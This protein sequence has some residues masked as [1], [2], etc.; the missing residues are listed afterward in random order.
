[1]KKVQPRQR[2]QQKRA[3]P[4]RYVPHEHKT[5]IRGHSCSFR[6]PEGLHYFKFKRF[7]NGQRLGVTWREAAAKVAAKHAQEEQQALQPIKLKLGLNNA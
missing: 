3:K 7:H 6:G 1:M 5:K 2:P 4:R